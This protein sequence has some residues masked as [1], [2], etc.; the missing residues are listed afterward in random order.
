M[1]YKNNSQTTLLKKKASEIPDS[2]F[3]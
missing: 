1:N 2:R 3:L